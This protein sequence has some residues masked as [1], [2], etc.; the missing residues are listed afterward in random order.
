[1]QVCRLLACVDEL[2]AYFLMATPATIA[3][4][5]DAGLSVDKIEEYRSAFRLFDTDGSGRITE[6]KIGEVLN[7][8]FGQSF[9]TEDL[10]YMLRQFSD[11]GSGGVDFSTFALALHGKMADPRYNDAFGDAFDLFDSGKTGELTKADL[12]EGMAKLG[13]MLTDAEAEEMLKI[14][15]KKDDFVR[16]MSASMAAG[17]PGAAMTSSSS[18]TTTAAATATAA[19]PTTMPTMMPP[20]V[21]QAGGG[22]PRPGPPRPAGGPPSPAGASPRPPGPPGAPSGGAPRP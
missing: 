10:A 16:A 6:D 8:K 20:P 15:K 18:P 3:A 14:A 1:M 7:G 19:T 2:V 22:P 9:A 13:E 5:K 17:T 11:S 12:V 4:L 21:P